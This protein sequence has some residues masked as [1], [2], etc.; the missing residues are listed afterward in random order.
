MVRQVTTIR[1]ADQNDEVLAA[2]R[3][4]VEALQENMHVSR[5]AIA[6][7]AEISSRRRAGMA[8]RIIVP[9][10]RRP[11]I[12][13]MMRESSARLIAAA[14]RLQRLEAGALYAEGMTMDQ[15]A[16]LFGLTRQRVSTLLRDESAKI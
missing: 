14:S 3:D 15:I 6:R 13:E 8:Y 7:A 10:E 1:E 4:L 5:R 2:L 11:L 16:T 9:A 12:V